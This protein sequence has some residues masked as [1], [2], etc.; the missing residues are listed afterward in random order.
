MS[1]TQTQNHFLKDLLNFFL[2]SKESAFICTALS[3]LVVIGYLLHQNI[4][5]TPLSNVDFSILVSLGDVFSSASDVF[6]KVWNAFGTA[7]LWFMVGG[8]VYTIG[9]GIWVFFID[10]YNDLVVSTR[11]VHPRSF[12]QSSYWSGIVARVLLRVAA[13][14]FFLSYL[15]ALTNKKFWNEYQSYISKY[16]DTEILWQK[17]AVSTLMVLALA[18]FF[19]IGIILIRFIVLRKRTYFQDSNLI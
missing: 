14:S 5:T 10:G 19:H 6:S 13:V 8:I 18:I 7:L 3:A 17:I 4:I 11:F 16:L 12:H 9:W 2:P 15:N 1:E